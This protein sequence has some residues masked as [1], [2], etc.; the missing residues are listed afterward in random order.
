LEDEMAA[1]GKHEAQLC[2][3]SSKLLF[4]RKTH[5]RTSGGARISPFSAV[6]NFLHL[7]H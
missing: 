6:L 7:Y 2:S 1:Q 5:R 4:R 3:C